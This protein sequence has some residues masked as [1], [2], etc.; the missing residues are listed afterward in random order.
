MAPS[1][2][3]SIQASLAKLQKLDSE[4]DIEKR[5]TE[6]AQIA[7]IS[8]LVSDSKV[9]RQYTHARAE[10]V[11]KWLLEKLKAKD[12]E[13]GK[14]FRL[15][16][17]S[18][19]L[20][21]H[22]LDL[23]PRIHSARL[24]NSANILS[25]IQKTLGEWVASQK[26]G[27]PALVASGQAPQYTS[28]SGKSKKQGR[29]RKRHNDNMEQPL[30]PSVI[31]SPEDVYQLVG[32]FLEKLIA[33]AQTHVS[34]SSKISSEHFR[35][36]LR[37]PAQFAAELLSAGLTA[38]VKCLQ[39]GDEQSSGLLKSIFVIWKLR[40]INADDET[41]A[42]TALFSDYC[43]V[44]SILLYGRLLDLNFTQDIE[45]AVRADSVRQKLD[46]LFKEHLLLPAR[47]SFFSY[48]DEEDTTRE[49]MIQL[50]VKS[51]KPLQETLSY[52]YQQDLLSETR[53]ILSGIPQFYRLA[54]EGSRRSTPKQRSEEAPWL[55]SVLEVLAACSGGKLSEQVEYSFFGRSE[56]TAS[57]YTTKVP[58]EDMLKLAKEYKLEISQA[59]L[60]EI[61]IRYSRIIQ[62]PIKDKSS[63]YRVRWPLVKIILEID[64]GLFADAGKQP[65][66]NDKTPEVSRAHIFTQAIVSHIS[67]VRW[68][69]V[70]KP[71]ES[72]PS[73]YDQKRSEFIL[74]IVAGLM[75]A[76]R[77]SRKLDQFIRLWFTQISEAVDTLTP[78]ALDQICWLDT[79]LIDMVGSAVSQS[80]STTQI[81]DLLD[82]YT[83]PVQK[84]ASQFGIEAVS[85]GTINGDG[86]ALG[87]DVDSI[88]ELYAAVVV[89]ES[90]LDHISRDE[91][92]SAIEPL[93][94][95]LWKLFQNIM[96]LDMN[97]FLLAGRI[98]QL[99]T[100][101][102]KL[103]REMHP[104]AKFYG[105]N[106]YYLD[107][108][109]LDVAHKAAAKRVSARDTKSYWEAYNA[110]L[111]FVTATTQ[112]VTSPKLQPYVQ[113]QVQTA[114]IGFFSLEEPS[115]TSKQQIATQLQTS[116]PPNFKTV[117]IVM[118]FPIVL[119][120]LEFDER[121]KL[122]KQ[123]VI[124]SRESSIKTAAKSNPKQS[125]FDPGLHALQ[126]TIVTVHDKAV[127]LTWLMALIE[128]FSEPGSE[129]VAQDLL[130]KHPL[131]GFKELRETLG[132]KLL[133]TNPPDDPEEALQRLCLV[134][135]LVRE[136]R[137]PLAFFEH[138]DVLWK[139]AALAK[140]L[141]TIEAYNIFGALASRVLRY[142]YHYF[143]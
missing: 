113:V 135:K 104:K 80:L 22:L 37:T 100:Q 96:L 119:L 88:S 62:A 31:F 14:K 107:P 141:G 36:I 85:G 86:P 99:L 25:S 12:E 110:Y 81:Q 47:A 114:S 6:A 120:S 16:P 38:S 53:L 26:A 103:Q 1:S 55:E 64:G 4:S 15:C 131:V 5:L 128:L 44:P 112:L 136:E 21:I 8:E 89:I 138:P 50:L 20:L 94:L 56:Q 61:L 63:L 34:E 35:S 109:V 11:L 18:W 2:R 71:T 24:L 102:R 142:P 74:D 79:A 95:K 29:K 90:I 7:G 115:D 125:D 60:G 127:N 13:L 3:G 28:D 83:L 17:F 84:M 41:G 59:M 75:T 54:I 111:F 134:Q 42:S 105:D 39:Q 40:S 121:V 51:W 108:R 93:V 129:K 73:Y 78:D 33:G 76:Y 52:L 116:E 106:N 10:W 97:E 49:Q 32:C 27:K 130:L 70:E 30:E 98:W 67:N 92:L 132:E 68:E 65:I 140:F 139:L 72:S 9:S 66:T 82:K 126:E 137:T 77:E 143:L 133:N 69:S 46:S 123:L 101:I 118:K 87:E 122:F 117:A 23:V 19:K 45:K 91:V 57:K 48:Q 124:T 58:F 43:L